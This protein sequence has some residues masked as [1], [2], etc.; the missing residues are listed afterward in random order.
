MLKSRPIGAMAAATMAAAAALAMPSGAASAATSAGIIEHYAG[1][2]YA[3][4]PGNWNGATECAFVSATVAYC[5]NNDAAFETFTSE[6]RNADGQAVQSSAS[7]G[8]ASPDTSGTC[9]GWAKIWDGANWTDTGLAFEDYGYLQNLA[10]Y[11]NTP[12][13]VRSWFTDGQRGY[14]A[15]TNCYGLTENQSQIFVLGL[16]TDAEATS[17]GPDGSYFIELYSGV[18]HF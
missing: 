9:N 14:S 17:M 3:L 11:V 13:E 7:A 8:S 15:M 6:P 10:N 5:F 2:T 12:F 16:S 18:S 4:T 1:Q